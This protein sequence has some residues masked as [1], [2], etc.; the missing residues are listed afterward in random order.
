MAFV[1]GAIA[2][3][4]GALLMALLTVATGQQMGWLAVAIGLVVGYAVR[5]FGKGV[6]PLFGIIGATLAMLG[7]LAG[8]LLSACI[9]AAR[10]EGQ[11]VTDR[12]AALTPEK[13]IEVMV[14]SFTFMDLIFYGVAIY[15]AYQYSFKRVTEEDLAL[16]SQGKTA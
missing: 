15:V 13:A 2:A 16:P 11:P 14:H 1:A 9:Y 12:L 6:T 8:N 7:C 10:R 3:M 5:L 4:L